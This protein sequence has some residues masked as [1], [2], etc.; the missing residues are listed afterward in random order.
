MQDAYYLVPV[1]KEHQKYL[2][3]SW[4]G[5]LYQYVCLPF[6]LSSAPRIFTKILKIL[7]ARLRAMGIRLIVYLDDILIMGTSEDEAKR[8][9]NATIELLQSVGFLISWEKSVL[10]PSQTMEFLGLE[11]DTRILTLSLPSAKVDSIISLCNFLLRQSQV[12]LR[13]IAKVLGNFSWSIPTVPFAQGHSRLLQHFYIR[14]MRFSHDL[15][16]LVSLPPEARLDLQWWVS[17]LR[18]CN[19]KA[20]LPACPDLSIHS[21]AS[22]QGWGA[23]CD[24]VTTRGPWPQVD[25]SRHINELELLGAFYALQTFTKESSN[26]SVQLLLDNTTAVAYVNKCGGTHSRTLSDISAKIINWCESRNISLSASHV[27]GIL[28]SVADLESRSNLDASD[29]MLLS[30]RFKALQ[31][32]WPADIDLF[33]AAWNRQLPK[34]VSWIPQ[35]NATAVNAFSLNWS[36]LKAYAFPPFALIPRC[37]LKIKRERANLILVCPLWPSQPWWPLLL[38]MA[39]DLPRVFRSH[40]L[41]L[42]SSELNPHPLLQSGKFLLSAWMLSGVA[43]KSEAFR[44]RLSNYCWPAPVPLQRLPTSPPGTNGVAGMWQGVS[45]PCLTL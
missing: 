25:R 19:G 16:K 30:I 45:I 13:D 23:V 36:N 4:K 37:L 5:I 18:L 41:L 22:L 10:I 42:H 38:E 20:I 7:I 9:L 40:H 3:F 26:I 24:N 43:S 33:A 6:G 12:K 27:P 29:W 2:R 34:F 35:P 44:R 39:T 11:I 1:T 17:H 14:S 15:N 21:D 31:A 28:N 32:I 8:H